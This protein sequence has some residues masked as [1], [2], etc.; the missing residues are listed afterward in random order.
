MQ[1]GRLDRSDAAGDVRLLFGVGRQTLEASAE[2][3]REGSY[4]SS[5]RPPKHAIVVTAIR[6]RPDQPEVAIV[7]RRGY[8]TIRPLVDKASKA[9]HRLAVQ[10][11]D[12]PDAAACRNQLAVAYRLDSKTT[13]AGRLFKRNPNSAA[14]ASALAARSSRLLQQKKHTEAELCFREFLNSR[15]RTQPDDWST[16]DAISCFGEALLDQKRFADAEPLLLSGYEGMNQRERSIPTQDK[17]HLT[18]ALERLVRLYDAW[19]NQEDAMKW[20]TNSRRHG[21]GPRGPH[22]HQAFTSQEYCD[23]DDLTGPMNLPIPYRRS[24]WNLRLH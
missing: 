22:E 11:P 14:E 4:A 23:Q 9:T 16:F 15:E 24:D 5:E 13:E 19:G 17:P 3:L 18:K 7:I 6:V 2:V 1:T 12:Q 10:G 20:Q 21:S 8:R